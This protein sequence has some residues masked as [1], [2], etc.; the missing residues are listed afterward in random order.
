[1][2]AWVAALLLVGGSYGCADQGNGSPAAKDTV[3][4]LYYEA[5]IEL[6]DGNYLQ[7]T[8]LFNRVARSPRYIRYAPLARL[9]VGDALY[10]QG[11]YEEAIEVYRAFMAQ[12]E[13]N[14]NMP[15]A[16]FR[17]ASAYFYRIPSAW[18]ASATTAPKA[19]PRPRMP[20]RAA[21]IGLPDSSRP[22]PSP[23]C[24]PSRPQRNPG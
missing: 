17:I 14:A 22:R 9:R 3:R 7:A 1:M 24:R 4:R 13:S 12:Y 10:L 18:F 5:M 11:R 19:F 15:Y 6:Q 20:R 8:Q 23:S 2:M 16:R 21:A